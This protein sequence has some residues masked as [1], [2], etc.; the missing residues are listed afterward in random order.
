MKLLYHTDSH[1][2]P[3]EI[4]DSR[5]YPEDS[6]LLLDK[7]HE[8]SFKV[9]GI[10]HGG[11]VFNSNKMTSVSYLDEVLNRYEAIKKNCLMWLVMGNHRFLGSLAEGYGR[12]V[13]FSFE[14][15]LVNRGLMDVSPVVE[16]DDAVL[17]LVHFS[18]DSEDYDIQP[19]GHKD[20]WRLGFYHDDFIVA[21]S[22]QD[23]YFNTGVE[24]LF[25]RFDSNFLGHIHFNLGHIEEPDFNVWVPGRTG[26]NS[27]NQCNRTDE[28]TWLLLDTEKRTVTPVP[29]QGTQ[30]NTMYPVIK[31]IYAQKA[32]VS[33]DEFLERAKE[34]IKGVDNIHDAIKSLDKAQ[35]I[36]LLMETI[37]KEVTS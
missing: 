36:K 37:S 34:N 35:D 15:F 7:L 18:P 21:R 31:Q 17:H 6:L 5:G 22:E 14:E 27:V 1:L 19:S 29:I 11:D 32:T 2:N 16:L 23:H 30:F 8:M 33:F 12:K 20:K 10:I 9:D 25:K 3:R 26:R 24:N 28:I 4:G 13:K